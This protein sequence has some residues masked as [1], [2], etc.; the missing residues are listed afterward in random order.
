MRTIHLLAL[1]VAASLVGCVSPTSFSGSQRGLTELDPSTE[2]LERIGGDEWTMAPQDCQGRLSDPAELTFRMASVDEHLVA[3]VDEDGV[4]VCVD[5]VEDVQDE[6]EVRGESAR[7]A[8]LGDQFLLGTVHAAEVLH[9]ASSPVRALAP[10]EAMGG[11]NAGDPTPQ[12][13]VNPRS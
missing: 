3:A 6:L 7:A 10:E 9:P 11:A 13:N 2:P 4:V 12:P 1:L 5:T 8:E